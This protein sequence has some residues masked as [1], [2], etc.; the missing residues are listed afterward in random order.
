[1]FILYRGCGAPETN[2]TQ[3]LWDEF[4]QAE[5]PSFGCDISMSCDTSI[6]STILATAIEMRNG[7]TD[8]DIKSRSREC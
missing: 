2:I 5:V 1:M 6:Q 8:D 7:D 3:G 4:R